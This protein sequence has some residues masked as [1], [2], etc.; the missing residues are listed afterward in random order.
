MKAYKVFLFVFLFVLLKNYACAEE[1]ANSIEDQF[2]IAI[3][4]EQ[5][6]PSSGTPDLLTPEWLYDNLSKNF[7][8]AYLNASQ[9]S[10]RKYLNT[11][12]FDLFI[13]PYG[14]SFPY[15][16]FQQ[17]KEYLFEGGGLLNIAGRPFW[18]PIDK[19]D[20]KW[21][22]MN[23]DDPYKEFLSPLGIKYYESLDNEDIGL[24]VTTSLGFTPIKPTHGNIFPYRIPARDFFFLEN[25]VDVKNKNSSIFVKSWRNPYIK[26]SLNIPHKWCLVGSRGEGHFLNP[27]NS[28]ALENLS[29]IIE[30]LACPII[31]YE[32]ETDLAAYY[33]REEVKVSLKVM[34][35]GKF[36]E[37]AVVDFEF[38][39]QD[40][41]IVYDSSSSMELNS[42]Q[43]MVLNEKWRPKKF[44]GS[45]YKIRAILKK[46]DIILDKEENGFVVIDKDILKKGPNIKTKG[47]KIIINGKEEFILGTNYY[48]S[49]IGE[50]MWVRPNILKIREDFKAMRGL[51]INFVRIHYHHSKWFRDYFSQVVKEKI[52]P[53]FQVTDTTALPSERSLRILDAI[54]QLAQEQGLIFC[55]DIFSLVPE[56]MGNP[57]GWLGLKE[58]IVDE[59][60]ITIHKKFIYLLARRYKD[61]PGITWDLWNEPRLDKNDL[62]ILKNWAKEIK[63]AFREHGDNHLITI[64]DDLS[65]H[66]L[67]ILDYACVHT[68]EP[69]EFAHIRGLDKPFIFQEV[70]DEAGCSLNEEIRQKDELTKDLNAFLKTQAAGFVPWQWTRQA[71]LWNNT[72][73]SEKWDDELGL[74]VHDNGT[75]KLG[76]KG[77]YYLINSI[78]ER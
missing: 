61:V 60:K 65:L 26:D 71:R 38:L 6:F 8:V 76:G 30:Y 52:D 55:M 11:E 68:Y 54:I 59:N 25:T 63:E 77:Y 40:G 16:V 57:I 13:L 78:K 34:N 7:S 66:F 28:I 58:R 5:D 51:G 69:A 74:C 50:L 44:H 29:K 62:D 49:K 47:N 42:G 12:N 45:F 56:E 10:D 53:Y 75:L 33:Q 20:G 19:I 48:E 41:K 15:K 23:V 43:R 73:D 37:K 18:A 22:K 1:P 32:L 24:S 21:K 64:G 3:F 4:K 9:L 36:K 72:S 39:D 67:D 31:I 2:R 70:W 14:E 35:N 46:D 17:I 27:K